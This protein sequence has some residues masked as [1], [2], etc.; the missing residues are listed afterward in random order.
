MSNVQLGVSKGYG[1]V[2][3]A[4]YNMATACGITMMSSKLLE[5]ND[6]AH[7]MTKRFD[8]EAGSVKHH[9]QTL[10]G[11][12]HFD[13]NAV[14]SYSYEQLFQTMRELKLPY[15]DAEQMFLRMVFNVAARN[16]DDHTKNFGFRLKKD[17]K[18]E[19]AP[20]Y[21]ICHAYQPKHQWVSEHS[22]S[23]NGKRTNITKEDLLVIGKSIKN[24]KAEAM[25]E[26]INDVV[27]KWKKYA[28]E[29]G[30]GRSLRDEIGKTLIRW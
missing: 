19:L 10:C 20:A 1:R 26:L 28:D 15:P 22:L 9:I 29:V 11:M 23:I 6:R 5:E 3:M 8:R 27:G 30:V 12:N 25:I 7:F 2:E 17:E 16:C 4:Y 21:D 18:W 24:K 13:F 14:N